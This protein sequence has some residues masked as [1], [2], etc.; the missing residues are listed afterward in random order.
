MAVGKGISGALGGAGVGSIFG[1]IG[2]GIGGLVGG[3]AGLFSDDEDPNAALRE[4]QARLDRIN[5]PDLTRAIDLQDYEVGPLLTAERRAALP[6]EQQ[7][8]I[9]LIEN[10]EMRAK[11]LANL[12][13]LERLAQ[14]GGLG[15]QERL[16]LEQVALKSSQ[17]L[18]RNLKAMESEAQQR[19]QFGGPAMLAA[20]LVGIQQASQDE[21]M[22]AQQAA[23]MAAQN[24]RDALQAAM[25]G[26]ERMRGMDLGA[27]QANVEARRRKQEFDIANSLAREEANINRAQAANISNVDAARRT[28]MM[29]TQGRREEALRRG[30][31]APQ[32]MAQNELA[33]AGAYGT[34]AGTQAQLA[35]QQNVASGQNWANIAG[36]G[37]GVAGTMLKDRDTSGMGWTTWGP[38]VKT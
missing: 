15:P 33:K 27:E 17:D 2:A 34:L 30:Y 20:Q 35:Q 38:K 4:Q 8:A 3:I 13:A 22:R 12:Q 26:S 24:R 14:T 7:A 36:A 32:I 21:T 6:I 16:A 18:S 5:L 19:G 23:A 11:Q 37:L 9:E 1:P 28:S 25:A 29:N 10:P 31:L